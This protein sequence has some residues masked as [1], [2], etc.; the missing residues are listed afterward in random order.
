MFSSK[1]FVAGLLI[2]VLITTFFKDK[3]VVVEPP[4]AQAALEIAPT[5]SRGT[6]QLKSQPSQSGVSSF[7]P[8][9]DPNL[10]REESIERPTD[11]KLK[12][13]NGIDFKALLSQVPSYALSDEIDR[14]QNSIF[15]FVNKKYPFPDKKEAQVWIG[16]FFENV[17]SVLTQSS[18]W[19]GE[20]QINTEEVK[21]SFSLILHFY[22]SRSGMGSETPLLE[23]IKDPSDLCWVAEFY[24]TKGIKGNYTISSCGFSLVKKDK[25]YLMTADF[26]YAEKSISEKWAYIAFTPPL[27]NNWSGEFD[28]LTQEKKWFKSTNL[29]WSPKDD[30]ELDAIKSQLIEDS[31][32]F[33]DE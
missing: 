17:N 29:Y 15:D 25:R 22:S 10:V 4:Y 24:F 26:A 33:I 2:G 13:A 6:A 27:N 20:G 14:R 12:K 30:S 28:F 31:S 1:S 8:S 3:K 5:Q 21:I 11:L 16:Q 19:L 23:N 7:D 9:E 18:V 32:S